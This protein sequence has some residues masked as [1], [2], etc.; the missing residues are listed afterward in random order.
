[1]ICDLQ[2]GKEGGNYI[3]T[4]PCVYSTMEHDGGK[5]ANGA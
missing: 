3:L 5:Y 4:D 2:G 1:M